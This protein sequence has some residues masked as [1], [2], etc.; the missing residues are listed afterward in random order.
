MQHFHI[1]FNAKLLEN[2]RAKHASLH[3][4][5][6][7]DAYDLTACVFNRGVLVMDTQQWRKQ[8]LTDAIEWWMEE[9]A[10]SDRPLYS[11]GLSQPPFLLSVYRDYKKLDLT[12]NT[13]GLGRH[14]FSELERDYMQKLLSS[15]PKKSPFISP[16][17]DFSKILHFNGKFKPWK[18]ERI[19]LADENVISFCGRVECAD[20]WWSYLSPAANSQLKSFS[21]GQV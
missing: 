8:K 1:Y 3:P 15:R 16:N 19:R 14:K 4:W 2:I 9:Y 20:I 5:L 21:L 13:R 11:Y 7:K 10:K 6:P 17:A 18:R 12:W